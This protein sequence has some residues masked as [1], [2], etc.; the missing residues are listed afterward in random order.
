MILILDQPYVNVIND[1]WISSCPV[2][3]VFIDI[4]VVV[5]VQS[6]HESSFTLEE[7]LEKLA[8]FLSND[9]LEEARG[10]HL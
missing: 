8:T 1:L 7:A 10:G 9:P 3:C 5:F 6:Y 4:F 2:F